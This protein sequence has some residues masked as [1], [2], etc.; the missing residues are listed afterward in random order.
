MAE[1]GGGWL[2]EDCRASRGRRAS[3]AGTITGNSQVVTMKRPAEVPTMPS[4]RRLMFLLVPAC[5]G[6]AACGGG[7][8]KP[9]AASGAATTVAGRA[10]QS[11][12]VAFRTCLQ[13][14]GV[15]LPTFVPRSTTPGETRPSRPQ[16]LDN[17]G[18]GGGSGGGFFRG[19]GGGFGNVLN[20][21]AA[22]KAVQ[23][24]QDKLPAGFLAQMQARRNQMNA[25]YSC[26]ADHGVTT[27]S[28]TPGSGPRPTLDRSSAAYA[29]CSAL[30][31]S[32]PNG[33]GPSVTTTAS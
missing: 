23:A 2:L 10:D 32:R 3:S 14:H 22:Q 12:V 30:L 27:T 1:F 15:T 20:D 28:G 24:C 17:G 6:F 9:A 31:P 16:G 18:P 8:S 19:G 33:P 5:L 21:P 13:Q 11:A 25:F 29:V 4:M 26:M 7:G